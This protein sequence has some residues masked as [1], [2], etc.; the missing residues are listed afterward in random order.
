[1]SLFRCAVRLIPLRTLEKERIF[2]GIKCTEKEFNLGFMH[3]TNED[4][5]W[6]ISH[7]ARKIFGNDSIIIY[8]V[9]DLTLVK[10]R[11]DYVKE[12]CFAHVHTDLIE[13][14]CITKMGEIFKNPTAHNQQ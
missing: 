3:L 10:S 7:L 14:N 9:I 8:Y 6:E 13:P 11:V 5:K 12:G 1:M 2:A 4:N